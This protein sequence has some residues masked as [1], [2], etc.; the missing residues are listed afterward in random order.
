MLNRVRES[1]GALVPRRVRRFLILVRRA[2]ERR[3]TADAAP[4]A[5]I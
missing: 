4:A 1:F 2:D 5:S 3:E